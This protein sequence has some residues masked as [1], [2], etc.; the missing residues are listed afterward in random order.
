MTW[1][2]SYPH[3]TPSPWVHPLGCFMTITV[4]LKNG[5][6]E[7]FQKSSARNAGWSLHEVPYANH[8]TWVPIISWL[9][10]GA[11]LLTFLRGTVRSTQGLGRGDPLWAPAWKLRSLDTV[12][13][14]T[15]DHGVQETS[16]PYY[17]KYSIS[18][19]SFFPL[20]VLAL[21]GLGMGSSFWDR[22]SPAFR[23]KI[24]SKW[25]APLLWDSPKEDIP[26]SF[27]P[28]IWL[29]RMRAIQELALLKW[30]RLKKLCRNVRATEP[31]FPDHRKPGILNTWCLALDSSNPFLENREDFI[32][33]LTPH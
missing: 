7:I 20:L 14:F 2:P 23:Q 32:R 17:T 1:S 24:I 16:H 30:P 26:P 13:R 3:A 28:L 10:P 12:F 19:P 21:Q 6:A 18:L 11:H 33:N 31:Q 25:S 5:S 8:P 9:I 29:W 22:S 27:S 15:W 4:N